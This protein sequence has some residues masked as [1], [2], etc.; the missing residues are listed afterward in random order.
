MAS[1][2]LH[3]AAKEY[4]KHLEQFA[5]QPTAANKWIQGMEEFVRGLPKNERVSDHMSTGQSGSS[6]LSSGK[7]GGNQ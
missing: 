5:S 7:M 3:H 2:S 6:G 1:E 4:E